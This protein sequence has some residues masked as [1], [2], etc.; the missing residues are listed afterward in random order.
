MRRELPGWSQGWQ[1]AQDGGEGRGGRLCWHTLHRNVQDR[2][3][4]AKDRPLLN[5]ISPLDRGQRLLETMCSAPNGFLLLVSSACHLGALSLY[6][7]GWALDRW[8]AV[9]LWGK[10]P[11]QQNTGE[12]AR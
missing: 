3:M 5:L 9:V 11:Q 4:G 12:T 6:P 1:S 7:E 2:S 8:W 10:R